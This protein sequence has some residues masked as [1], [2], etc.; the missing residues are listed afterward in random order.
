MEKYDYYAEVANDIENWL[1]FN[2]FNLSQFE[3]R[4]E[5]AMNFGQ[6]MT[7]LAMVQMDMRVKL[8]VKN[9]FVITGI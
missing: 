2:D 9:F 1:D 6:K 7:L 8:S 3:D 5:A 4:E